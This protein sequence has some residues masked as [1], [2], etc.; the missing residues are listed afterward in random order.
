MNDGANSIYWS[1][2]S[3]WKQNQSRGIHR[4]FTDCQF[5]SQSCTKFSISTLQRNLKVVKPPETVRGQ[6]TALNPPTGRSW[7]SGSEIKSA[8]YTVFSKINDLWANLAPNHQPAP[9]REK[10]DNSDHPEIVRWQ[11]TAQ[12]SSTRRPWALESKRKHA[13]YTVFPKN[14]DL[15]AIRPENLRNP[16]AQ[17]FCWLTDPVSLLIANYVSFAHHYC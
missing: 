11:T 8:V 10:I 4:F 16:T 9:F 13:A 15:W 2:L 7:A 3:L 14:D 1:P 5:L 6:T 12:S 17:V